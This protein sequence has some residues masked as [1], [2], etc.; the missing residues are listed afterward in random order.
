[1]SVD[2]AA[3]SITIGQT[4]TFTATIAIAP[5]GWG[6]LTGTV[7][8]G[9]GTNFLCSST[10]SA[11]GIALFTTSSL[12]VGTHEITAL[13]VGTATYYPGT[14]EAHTTRSALREASSLRPPALG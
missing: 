4:A 8:F 7:S 11:S 6:K 9:D 13:Y 10:V 12:S 1:M 5:P 3:H 2:S 14:E